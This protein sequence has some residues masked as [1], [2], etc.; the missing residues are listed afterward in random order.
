MHCG[1]CRKEVENSATFCPVVGAPIA[2]NGGKKTIIDRKKAGKLIAAAIVT[3][4]ISIVPVVGLKVYFYFQS[5]PTDQQLQ[6][7]VNNY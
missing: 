6:L 4:A 7:A 1:N 5:I 2:E 3:V